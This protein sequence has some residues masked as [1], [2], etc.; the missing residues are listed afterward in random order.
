MNRVQ[1]QFVAL[2]G[3]AALAAPAFAQTGDHAAC[4]K[5]KDRAKHGVFTLTVTNAGITQSCRVMVPARLGCLASRVSAVIRFLPAVIDRA[6]LE[7]RAS[8]LP[9]LEVCHGTRRTFS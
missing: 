7:T 2:L 4:Y 3:A 6:S 5:V 1:V 9:L 8:W